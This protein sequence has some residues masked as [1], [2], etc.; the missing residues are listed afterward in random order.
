M[1]SDLTQA[2]WLGTAGGGPVVRLRRN[3]RFTGLL[4]D[5]AEAIRAGEAEQVLGLVTAGRPRSP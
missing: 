3:Y 5:L 2:A 1:L 4:G